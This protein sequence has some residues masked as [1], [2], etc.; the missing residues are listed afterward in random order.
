MFRFHSAVTCFVFELEGSSLLIN[1]KGGCLSVWVTLQT[2]GGGGFPDT[3]KMG[4]KWD[5]TYSGLDEYVLWRT[6]ERGC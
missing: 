4:V 6:S 3:R 2:N 5:M 1:K